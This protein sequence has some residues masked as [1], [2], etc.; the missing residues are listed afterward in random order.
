M[1][2]ED[3]LFVERHCDMDRI[4][5]ARK[6]TK[7]D[8]FVVFRLQNKTNKWKKVMELGDS[9]LQETKLK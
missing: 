5:N 8:R 9:P 6:Q 1:L 3:M 7:I 4:G 2:T